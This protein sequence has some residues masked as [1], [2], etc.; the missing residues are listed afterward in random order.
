MCKEGK[1]SLSVLQRCSGATSLARSLPRPLR[2]AVCWNT[3]GKNCEC[4]A[5]PRS[6][7]GQ[8]QRGETPDDAQD[9]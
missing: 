5:S 8:Q 6:T 3:S 2:S 4:E 9:F 1:Q 7:A